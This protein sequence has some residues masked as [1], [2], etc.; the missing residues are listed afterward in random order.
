M[1]YKIMLV[2]DDNNLRAIYGDRL[3]AEGYDIVSARDG[4]EALAMAVKEK[5]NLIISDVMMP[6]ISGFDMLDILRTTPETKDVK[7]IMMTALSQAEDKERADKLGADKYLVK[8]QV[9]LEDV[10]RVVHE[11]LGDN[12]SAEIAEAST[13]TSAP[14]ANEAVAMPANAPD[15]AIQAAAANPFEATPTAPVV[16]PEAPVAPVAPANPFE[17]APVMPATPVAPANP[18]E[19][20]ASPVVAPAPEPMVAQ[21]QPTFTPPSI[22]VPDPTVAIP[23]PSPVVDATAPVVP[24]VDPQTVTPTTEDSMA[25]TDPTTSSKRVIQPINDLTTDAQPKI[26]ELYEKEM[27]EQAKMAP[28]GTPGA[29]TVIDAPAVQPEQPAPA[30]TTPPAQTPSAPG[31]VFDPNSVAL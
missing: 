17:A 31:A 29:N 9:T 30:P 28:V 20:P 4:E 19:A 5:P 15:P 16:V 6:K 18:F 1:T 2:E 8:S 21:P 11:V 13:E 25:T 26:Y 14:V 3:M 7:V 23:Q 12:G 24:T 27:A 10:A 22:P